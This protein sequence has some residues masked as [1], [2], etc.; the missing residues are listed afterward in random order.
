MSHTVSIV[1]V[2]CAVYNIA[3]HFHV[4]IRKTNV[5]DVKAN[6][7]EMLQKHSIRKCR[8]NAE[9]RFFS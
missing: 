3:Q 6:L 8:D 4:T 1:T 7:K 5:K 9:L 2:D